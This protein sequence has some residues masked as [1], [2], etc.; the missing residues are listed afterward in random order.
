MKP[1]SVFIHRIQPSCGLPLPRSYTTLRVTK[2]AFFPTP[3]LSFLLRAHFKTLT[4]GLLEDAHIAAGD[5]YW[6]NDLCLP[7]ALLNHIRVLKC[8][9][10]G[11]TSRRAT[12]SF[13]SDKGAVQSALRYQIQKLPAYWRKLLV[14]RLGKY[15]FLHRARHAAS[16]LGSRDPSLRQ[17]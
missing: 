6:L 13:I 5:G 17:W 1:D 16:R 9:L 12:C 14:T 4:R 3:K 15:S 7:L 11:R 10:R 2:P 8:A